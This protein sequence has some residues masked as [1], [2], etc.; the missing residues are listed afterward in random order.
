MKICEKCKTLAEDSVSICRECGETLLPVEK[1]LK[2]PIEQ[3][4]K[5]SLVISRRLASSA[6]SVIGVDANNNVLHRGFYKL[7]L[8]CSTAVAV[9]ASLFSAGCI[10]VT[11]RNSA[12]SLDSCPENSICNC[13]K[14]VSSDNSTVVFVDFNGNVIVRGDGESGEYEAA[15]WLNMD[16]AE[17][18]SGGVVGVTKDGRG[19][20]VGEIASQYAEINNWTN[21]ATIIEVPMETHNGFVGLK[22]DGTLVSIGLPQVM[23]ERLARAKTIVC[24]AAMPG[25]LFI[26]EEHGVLAGYDVN[27]A[28]MIYMVPKGVI[29]VKGLV[30]GLY[31]IH[32]DGTVTG[33]HSGYMDNPKVVIGLND[34]TDGCNITT[35]DMMKYPLAGRVSDWKL[36]NDPDEV[37][38]Q[39]EAFETQSYIRQNKCAFCGGDFKGLFNKK[40]VACGRIKCY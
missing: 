33:V 11:G 30:S 14:S 5:R 37:L 12:R 31:V 36:F 35:N 28:K 23:S 21:L 1:F 25:H 15:G 6:V 32:M 2:L 16:I 29:A 38:R 26:L 34:L 9:Y 4:I 22:K 10:T 13:I 20:V 7:E 19:R 8:K 27:N 3:R 17:L 18:V 40:C 39:Y 24:I